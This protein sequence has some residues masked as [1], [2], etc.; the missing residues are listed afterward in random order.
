MGDGILA[1][2]EI[3][4]P[5][6]GKQQHDLGDV[7]HLHNLE[8]KKPNTTVNGDQGL[9]DAKSYSLPRVPILNQQEG[10]LLEKEYG[11][12]PVTEKKDQMTEQNSKI[13]KVEG[14]QSPSKIVSLVNVK[15]ENIDEPEKVHPAKMPPD[16]KTSNSAS[17]QVAKNAEV[18]KPYALVPINEDQPKKPKK[19][20]QTQA[21]SVEVKQQNSAAVLQSEAQVSRQQSKEENYLDGIPHP[22]PEPNPH[23]LP[24]L[25]N[26]PTKQ[27]IVK[28]E[29]LKEEK[30]ERIRRIWK[31]PTFKL[32][33]QYELENLENQIK[34]QKNQQVYK[35]SVTFNPTG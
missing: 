2:G 33:H 12:Q 29:N 28:E 16:K 4:N 32:P 31:M 5:N 3:R 7:N 30:A 20:N 19:D 1:S 14:E 27:R 15:N 10:L 11:I 13:Q 17:L 23:P 34:S 24:A 21:R 22:N 8:I 18:M 26:I 6:A 35:R 25:R 9:P